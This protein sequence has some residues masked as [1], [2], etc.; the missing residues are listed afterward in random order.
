M[1]QRVFDW[2]DVSL[3]SDFQGRSRPVP[4]VTRVPA[5]RVS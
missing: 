2:L 3:M 5:L 4:Q 1:N